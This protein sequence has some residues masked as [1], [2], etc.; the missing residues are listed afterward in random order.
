MFLR[1]VVR[2]VCA[3]L[4]VF[5]IS[6]S[7]QNFGTRINVT[8]IEVSATV[9]DANGNLPGDLKPGV[10]ELTEDSKR[11]RIIGVAYSHGAPSVV[12]PA[13]PESIG[14]PPSK[15]ERPRQVVIYLQQSLSTTGGLRLAIKSLLPHV[16]R[17][18]AMGEVEVVTDD[19]STHSLLGPTQ[20]AAA[21][22]SLFEALGNEARGREEL[23][24][25]RQ[26]F[27]TGDRNTSDIDDRLTRR[28]LVRK[29]AR[30]EWTILRA[31]QDA[32]FAWLSR[33]PRHASVDSM[34]TPK[35]T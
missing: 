7:G 13:R 10:F 16:D 33:F 18:V 21:L 19:P 23:I 4:I 1:R 8:P 28:S 25:I 6:S 2:I 3:G 30:E 27:M 24:R 34:R 17:L 11:Q 20:D 14:T 12:T 22:R 15:P 35:Q 31:Q 26:E 29:A 32:M 5:P 9:R